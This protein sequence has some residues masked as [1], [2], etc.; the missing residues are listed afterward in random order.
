MKKKI[1][2]KV[3]IPLF[4]S[5]GS[6]GVLVYNKDQNFLQELHIGSKRE[7]DKLLRVLDDEP[8]GYFYARVEGAA[9]I[10][11]D[12]APDQNW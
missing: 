11:T 6:A 10:L 7:R 3:Q 12:R 8:K 5:D 4:S 1:I 9:L 2:V